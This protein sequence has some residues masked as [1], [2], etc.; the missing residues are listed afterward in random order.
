MVIHANKKRSNNVRKTTYRIKSSLEI[1]NIRQSGQ[2]FSND[3][4]ALILRPN[5]LKMTRVAVLASKSVG[6]AVQ[7]NRCKRLLRSR[8]VQNW[9]QI[10]PGYDLLVIARKPL[11]EASP[12]E[13]DTSMQSLL[14]K[15]NL[16]EEMTR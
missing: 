3:K 1:Q 7:R 13:I 11:L 9:Q 4:I 2:S 6:G 14:T 16:I 12:N 10:K 5:E 15:A 8:L